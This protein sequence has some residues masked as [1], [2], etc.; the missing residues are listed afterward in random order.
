VGALGPTVRLIFAGDSKDL[1]RKI[2][3]VDAK[4]SSWGSKIAGIGKGLGI[5]AAGNSA[6]ATIGGA[7]GAV[8]ALTGAAAVLPAV[9]LAGAAA[10]GT[11]KLATE[12]FGEAVGAGL[13]GDV[14]AFAEATAKMHPEMAKAAATAVSFKPKVDE[15]RKAVQGGFWDQ[16][17]VGLKTAGD[18]Y[19]PM[20]RGQLP[21][22]STELG[23]MAKQA[24]N[25]ST[26][27][28][29]TGA[30]SS[31]L[32]STTKTFRE[33]RS[34]AADVLT[35]LV[36]IGR[37]GAS[38]LPILGEN[39]GGVTK[40]F[41]DWVTSFEGRN[42]IQAWINGGILAFQQLG[43]I[44][45]NI[46]S[47]LGS[48]FTG[49]GGSIDSPLAKVVLFT[50]KLAEFAASPGAQQALTA[51]GVAAQAAGMLMGSVFLSALSALL[52]V[53]IAL[54][55]LVTT[56]ATTL[57]TWAPVLGP[58]V[59]A[60]YAFNQA[61]TLGGA[62]LGAYN[63]VMD[64]AKSKLV[65]TAATWIVSHATMAAS[66]IATGI[67]VL[68]SM[69]VTAATYVAQWVVM[70]AGAMARAVVMAAAWVVA[71]GPV[72]WV[73][74]A[75]VGLVALVIA[76]WDTVKGAT[77][78]AWSAVSGAVSSAWNAIKG[79]VSSAASSVSSTIS[80]AWNTVKSTTVSAWNSVKSAASSGISGLMSLVMSLPG[81]I[82]GVF[83]NVG[84]WLVSS[85]RS[86]IEGLWR[87][88][89]GA[90]GWVTGMIS[91]ALTSIRNLFP[92]SPAKE[93]PFSGTGYTTYSGQALMEDFGK[94]IQSADSD[95]KSAASSVLGTAST[96]LAGGSTR[97]RSGAGGSGGAVVSFTGNTSDAL[98]TVIMAMIRQ[99][100]IQIKAA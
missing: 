22:I 85:G 93:G 94:G 82:T 32:S 30:V 95:V 89:Q 96:S 52:P 51:L 88:I 46:G 69:A 87:G 8:T 70:A 60:A 24:V 17:S 72:G 100:K 27:P 49:L 6:V 59:V 71:M 78:A 40:R 23:N 55:P 35:G 25:A 44:A 19:L 91:G 5:L 83:R 74:A 92:F 20:L 58:L 4:M 36:G 3:T 73:I 67:S 26:T 62:A 28:F 33:M 21:T 57:A 81:R 45:G 66:A 34:S 99:G 37:I 65:A 7:V 9:A 43:Q 98:A 75:V 39:I 79:W 18:K 29:F 12:G 56:V 16:F 41:K 48:V 1:E 86:L 61:L 64:L 50:Q 53:I 42:Q 63:A 80:S 90:I 15:L 31:I 38:H 77:L 84:Q 14:E 10:M 47:T 11:W 13:T 54:A 97:G 68:A 2:K 76:N